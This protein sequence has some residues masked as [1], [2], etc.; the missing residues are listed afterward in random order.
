MPAVLFD[1]DGVIVDSEGTYTEF[2][3]SIDKLYPTG[4]PDFAIAIKGTNLSKILSNYHNQEVRDDIVRRLHAFEAE[5]DYPLIPG[6]A[7][8]LEALAAKSIKSALV[9][10]SDNAKMDCL[11]RKLPWL[12]DAF[13]AIV[14]GS[15]VTRS[16][17]DPEGYILG[18]SMLGIDPS[19][20][21]VFEDSLQ[22][23]RAGRASGAKVIALATTNPHEAVAPLA[24]MVIDTFVGFGIDDMLSI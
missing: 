24:D 22:G 17:P 8:F 19:E 18:A 14:T 6:A 7:E 2:W 20:C 4:I 16:K 21:Y 5:M 10:S 3:S 9:T 11:F 1:L 13:G 12:R 23:L 15:M